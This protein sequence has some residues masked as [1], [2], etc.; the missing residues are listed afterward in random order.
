[1]EI[2]WRPKSGKASSKKIKQTAALKT[3]RS[4]GKQRAL[5]NIDKSIELYEDDPPFQAVEDDGVESELDIIP[6]KPR[7]SRT[8]VTRELRGAKGGADKNVGQVV[9]KDPTSIYERMLNL[10]KQVRGSLYNRRP[11]LNFLLIKLAVQ[12]K[13]SEE[14]V[15][16]VYTLQL[17]SLT[18]PAGRNINP[19]S[20]QFLTH[21]FVF[22]DYIAFKDIMRDGSQD[23]AMSEAELVKYVDDQYDRFGAEFLNLCIEHKFNAK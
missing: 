1:V 5:P 7:S 13:I 12:E 11:Q 22:L 14:E 17:L 21:Y 16:D 19:T 20:E 6:T 3:P 18:C 8:T 9:K 23:I 2:K 10:R 4:K 15:M